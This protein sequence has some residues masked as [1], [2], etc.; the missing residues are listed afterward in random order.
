M[1]WLLS[2]AASLMLLALPASAAEPA[3]L[4][5]CPLCPEMVV[6]PAGTVRLGEGESGPA[7]AV[8]SVAMGRTEVTRGQWS[9]CVADGGCPDKAVRWPEPAMPMTNISLREAQDY[10][11]WLSRRT[12]RSYRLPDE[13]EWEYAAKAGTATQFPWGDSM[14]P[15]RAVCHQCDPRFHR[16]PAPVATMAAN[17]FGLFD[18]N[19]NVWEWT[20]ACW[21]TGCGKRVIKGGSWYFVPAQS[22]SIARASQDERAW[23]YDVGFRVVRTP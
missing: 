4:R 5:D 15:G 7:R 23:G 18:M 10:A 3:L 1:A 9:A 16:R 8:A 11:V 6:L 19:G 21:A 14:E 2:F 20:T 22:R 12:G 17:P 13:A